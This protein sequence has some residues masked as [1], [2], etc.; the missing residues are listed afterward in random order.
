MIGK[1]SAQFQK[2]RAIKCGIALNSC[3][4][5]FLFGSEDPLLLAHKNVEKTLI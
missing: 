3:T 2:D 1:K 5:S 4:F